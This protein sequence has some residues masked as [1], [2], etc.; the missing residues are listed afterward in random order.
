MHEF[1]GFQDRTFIKAMLRQLVD[2]TITFND[3]S[4]TVMVRKIEQIGK[5]VKEWPDQTIEQ[6]AVNKRFEDFE[7]YDCWFISLP[8]LLL[9]L[10]YSTDSESFYKA[11]SSVKYVSMAS[12]NFYFEFLH[13][14]VNKFE[15]DN[16]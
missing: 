13:C 5:K 16:K 4:D 14:F 7:F 9:L 12:S 3:P 15:A 8:Q 6:L 1:G 10:K 11:L 2:T